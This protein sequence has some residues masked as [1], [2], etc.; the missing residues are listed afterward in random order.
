MFSLEGKLALVT[1]SSRGLGYSMA[2][3]L[4][5]AGAAV[6]V[7]GRNEERLEEAR[8]SLDNGK[9]TLHTSAFDAT[10]SA[11]VDAAIGDIET[12]IGPI[13][14]LFNNAGIIHRAPILEMPEEEWRAV[15]DAN[16]TAPFLV[17]R[18][19]ARYMVE[20]GQGK[21]VNTCSLTSEVARNTVSPYSSSKG[22]LKLLTQSMATEWAR[23]NIQVNGIGPG[24]FAT[25]LTVPL[26]NDPDFDGWVKTRTP[27]ARWGDPDELIGPAVFLASDAS[28]F[29]N[30]HVLYVDGGFLATM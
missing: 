19:V 8:R 20:R 3:G 29:V 5:D 28:S 12:N 30:G 24:F 16:L 15:I 1:G 23:H 10:D 22:G 4:A 18:A 26:Q 11:A 25:K 7:N 14:I 27:A 21:I 2:K 17:G 13:D 9:R 6:I